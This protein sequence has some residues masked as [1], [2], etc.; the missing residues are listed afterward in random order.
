MTLK[1]LKV[2]QF[3]NRYHKKERVPPTIDDVRKGLGYRSTSSPRQHLRALDREGF[4]RWRGYRSLY[5]LPRGYKFLRGMKMY[6][7]I[8]F[9]NGDISLDATES[10]IAQIWESIVSFD[11]ET[12]ECSEHVDKDYLAVMSE[13]EG[14]YEI[15]VRCDLSEDEKARLVAGVKRLKEAA[16]K[17]HIRYLGPPIPVVPDDPNPP[18]DK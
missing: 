8:I 18:S 6:V 13:T 7:A 12:N 14:G 11:P 3:I 16:K 17:E 9:E 5:I 4:I 10:N 15:L 1:R 2:L